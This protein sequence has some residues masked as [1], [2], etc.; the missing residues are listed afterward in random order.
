MKNFSHGTNFTN[1]WKILHICE[2]FYT[3]VKIFTHLWKTG[4]LGILRLD[5]FFTKCVKFFTDVQNLSQMCKIVCEKFLI[6]QNSQETRF[7][8]MCKNFHICVIFFTNRNSQ[9][10]WFYTCEKFYTFVKNFTQMWKFFHRF[11]KIFPC[12]KFLHGKIDRK[13]VNFGP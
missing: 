11:V 7:S 10:T 12:E 5:K 4:P 8:R 2:K 13:S 6:A 3:T 9:E 1:P